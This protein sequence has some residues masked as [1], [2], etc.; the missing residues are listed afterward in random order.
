MSGP[1]TLSTIMRWQ[2]ADV[3]E[4]AKL[5]ADG[6]ELL[7]TAMRTDPEARAAVRAI[8]N[9]FIPRPEDDLMKR[10]GHVAKD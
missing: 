5:D 6:Y 3:A 9:S 1:I 8:V 7:K 4:W 10:R 2:L